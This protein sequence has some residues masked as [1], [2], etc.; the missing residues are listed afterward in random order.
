MSNPKKVVEALTANGSQVAGLHLKEFTLARLLMLEKIASPL[1]DSGRE[2]TS[3]D[4]MR[5][6]FILTEPSEKSFLLSDDMQ[7]FDAAAVA[8]AEKLRPADLDGMRVAIATLFERAVSTI[9]AG[10]SQKKT[11]N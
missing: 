2:L 3:M 4:V 6:L 1:L 5:L 9:P 7:R 10:P 8:L 11:G